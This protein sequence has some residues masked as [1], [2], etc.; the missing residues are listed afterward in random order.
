MKII[1]FVF[2]TF[3]LL[4][5]APCAMA[6]SSTILNSGVSTNAI[7]P[8]YLT[9]SSGISF[10]SIIPHSSGTGTVSLD[11]DGNVTYQYSDMKPG[12]Q[13]G[14]I[15]AATFLVTGEPSTGFN[16]SSPSVSYGSSPSWGSMTLSC[17]APSSS[18]L[19]AN[20]NASF[21]LWGTLSVPSNQSAGHYTA[22]VTET[23]TYN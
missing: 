16:I 11:G 12:T 22:T 13:A 2:V 3:V 18:A 7:T 5:F 14:T 4:G 9:N 1:A 8:L 15:N 21:K 17:S 6:Q 19:D 10:G 20:G 23:V